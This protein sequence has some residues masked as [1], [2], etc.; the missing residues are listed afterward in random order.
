ML[1]KVKDFADFRAVMATY[2]V[3][4]ERGV[5]VGAFVVVAVEAITAIGALVQYLPAYLLH[6]WSVELRGRD[7]DQFARGRRFIDCG[8]GAAQPCRSVW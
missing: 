3:L 1:Y 4:P 7:D 6:R 5:A 2:N 8:G